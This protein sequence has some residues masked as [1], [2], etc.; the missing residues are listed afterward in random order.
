M[1]EKQSLMELNDDA[2]DLL[3]Q[4]LAKNCEHEKEV[5]LEKS[6]A[7]TK[8]A[9][10]TYCSER[11]NDELMQQ[12][13]VFEEKLQNTLKNLETSDKCRMETLRKQ[14][15]DDLDLQQNLMTCKQI[16]ETMHMMV[17]NEKH[18][19]MKMADMKND[20]AIPKKDSCDNQSKSL[21]QLWI[22]FQHQ[23][24]GE[25]LQGDEREIFDRIHDIL[26]ELMI[27]QPKP[28]GS[29]NCF[30][31]QEPIT[32]NDDAVTGE[33]IKNCKS[34]DWIEKREPCFRIKRE[35]YVNVEWTNDDIGAPAVGTFSSCHRFS[36]DFCNHN[37]PCSGNQRK[38]QHQSSRW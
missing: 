7:A 25:R 11:I 29:V 28:D 17:T 34:V 12:S 31:I 23:L 19:C 38:L 37:V 22:E 1:K 16:T 3:R 32:A 10:E 20:F 35:P 8:T 33:S 24:D 13:I 15:L 9:M 36:I 4:F 6:I 5:L 18:W 30:I 21:K 27:K 26:G 2:R 14:C